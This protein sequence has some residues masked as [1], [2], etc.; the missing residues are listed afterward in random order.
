MGAREKLNELMADMRQQVLETMPIWES[1]WARP[2]QFKPNVPQRETQLVVGRS[3]EGFHRALREGPGLGGKLSYYSRACG[4]REQAIAE[5]QLD[6]A[7]HLKKA[8][9]D[10]AADQ[11]KGVAKKAVDEGRDIDPKKKEPPKEPWQGPQI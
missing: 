10:H 8:A 1:G 11:Q 9:P 5:G 3:S 7:E 4:T 6:L 2:T